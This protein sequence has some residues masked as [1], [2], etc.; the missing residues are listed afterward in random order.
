MSLGPPQMS[1]TKQWCVYIVRCF[2]DTLYT[3]ATNNLLKRIDKHN[4]GKGAKYTRS[5]LPVILSWSKNVDSKSEALKL[6]WSIKKLTRKQ[7]ME[8]INDS[9][10]VEN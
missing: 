7:K 1:N 3:G 8:L 9:L 5:R 10:Y 6:E 4:S 2:D